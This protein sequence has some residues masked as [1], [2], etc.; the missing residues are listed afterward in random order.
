LFD[1]SLDGGKTFG[2][3]IFITSQPGGWAFDVDGIFRCNGLPITA[4]DISRSDYRGHI[5]VVWSDQRNS[6]DNT[7]VFLIKSVDGGE[8]WA[9]PVQ[10][11]ND[12][13]NRH[14]FFPWIAIDPASGFIYII[15]YDRRNTSAVSTDVY[16][17]RSTDGGQSFSNRKI[18]ESSFSPNQKVFFGDYINIAALNGKIYPIWMRMD[19]TV[20]SIWSAVLHDSMNVAVQQESLVP[21]DFVL[22]QNY[23]NPF[24]SICQ[25]RYTLPHRC[26]VSLEIYDATGRQVR[27]LVNETQAPDTYSVSFDGGTLSSG[28]YFYTLKA[29][30]ASRTN[31]MLFL[32]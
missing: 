30:H 4:C 32:R 28:L 10:V 15:F 3:D 27:T 5:Y 2:K 31:K 29:G 9:T 17:A 14:Q 8:T 21:A 12:S 20:L 7:D 16:L 13:T 26:H 23:P 18:S 6:L 1:R 11:N 25:I 19:E 22:F 24:N